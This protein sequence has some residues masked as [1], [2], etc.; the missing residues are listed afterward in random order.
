VDWFRFKKTEQQFLK[1][2]TFPTASGSFTNKT[3]EFCAI[4]D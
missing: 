3:A 2:P 1:S 4:A